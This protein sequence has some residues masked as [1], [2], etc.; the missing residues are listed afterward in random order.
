MN[1]FVCC[2]RFCVLSEMCGGYIPPHF[3]LFSFYVK[4][5]LSIYFI[6]KYLFF[7][8]YLSVRVVDGKLFHP[9]GAWDPNTVYVTVYSKRKLTN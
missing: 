3:A 7:C 5:I 6:Y 9:D 2:F 1:V 4:H 8:L